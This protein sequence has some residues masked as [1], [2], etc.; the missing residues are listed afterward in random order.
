MQSPAL[1]VQVRPVERSEVPQ[2]IEFLR[3]GFQNLAHRST[4]DLRRLFEYRW[5]NVPEKP[6]LGFA[7][8][9]GDAVVGYLGAIYAERSL[10]DAVVK[11]A[12]FGVWYVDP[13][14]RTSSIR[15]MTSMLSDKNYSFLALTASPTVGKVLEAFGCKIIDYGK[16]VYLPWHVRRDLCRFSPKFITDTRQIA[17]VVGAEDQQFLKDHLQCELKHYVF[18]VGDEYTYFILKRRTFPGVAAFPKFPVRKVRLMW[19]PC[20]EVLHLRN[21]NLAIANWGPQVATILRRERVLGLVV[22]E[23]ILG[24]D[25][26]VGARLEHRNYLLARTPLKATV[27]SLYSELA[28][29]T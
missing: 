29:L 1:Q 28:L 23:R 18:Q 5:P 11:V 24:P 27:D 26:P 3:G 14:F 2:V 10:G 20:M 22:A 8:W 4:D 21:P 13:D 15:L 25:P 9:S 19:Y 7:L 6:Y 12:N 16:R 17:E